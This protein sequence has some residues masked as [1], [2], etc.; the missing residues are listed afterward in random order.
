M[1]FLPNFKRY[2]QK[3][4]LSI[5]SICLPAPL[6]TKPISPGRLFFSHAPPGHRPYVPEAWSLTKILLY[7][8]TL[9][10]KLCFGSGPKMIAVCLGF[11]DRRLCWVMPVAVFGW[12]FQHE[13]N[14]NHAL[15]SSFWCREVQL[16]EFLKHATFERVLSL[17]LFIRI[18]FG[19]ATGRINKYFEHY[20]FF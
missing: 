17:G 18:N 2:A 3:I 9:V 14:Q 12:L 8:W 1:V 15:F 10:W 4:I 11:R 5:S 13:R 19:D 7:G 20:L 6:N 16:F